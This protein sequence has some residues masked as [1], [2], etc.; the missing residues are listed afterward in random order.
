M[1]RVPVEEIHVKISPPGHNRKVGRGDSGSRC[2]ALDPGRLTHVDCNISCLGFIL[3]VVFIQSNWRKQVP[4]VTV[5]TVTGSFC[6]RPWL[7]GISLPQLHS[8]KSHCCGYV[9]PAPCP[10]RLRGSDAFPVLVPKCVNITFRSHDSAHIPV[11]SF[12]INLPLVKH[13]KTDLFSSR[14]P[15]DTVMQK[16]LHKLSASP[17]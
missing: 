13:F 7:L 15:S 1:A 10:L 4:L 17:E 6:V 14:I 5:L 16:S 8:C 2:P 12:F 11:N 9:I 3:W